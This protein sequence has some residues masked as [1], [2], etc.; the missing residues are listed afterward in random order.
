MKTL[1]YIALCCAILLT[2][3]SCAAPSS[4]ASPSDSDAVVVDTVKYQDVYNNYVLYQ[5]L[6]ATEKV[7]YGM[8][9][10]A[11]R[12]HLSTETTIE[13]AEGRS[14][15]GI[16][17]SLANARLS[18]EE[19]SRLFESFYLD[20]PEFFFIDRTYSLA[21][22]QINNQNVYDTLILQY[23]MN[24]EQRSAATQQLNTAVQR[25]LKDRP[26]TDDDFETE[27][28]LHDALLSSRVYDQAA[29]ESSAKHPNAYSAYGAL[30]QGK[31]VCE[32]YAKAMQILLNSVSIPTTVVRGFS[33]ENQT[34]HMWNLVNINGENYYLDPTWND[35][36]P[37]HHYSYFN[38][39][40][41]ALKRTHVIDATTPLTTDCTAERDNYFIR[42]GTYIADYDRDTIADTIARQIQ[43]GSTAVH[44]QFEDGKYENGL[45][46]LKNATLTK[47]MVDARLT[48]GAHM[49]D[50][51]LLV[52]A[53]QNT[54]SIHKI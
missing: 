4:P 40:S 43:Q 36:E 1:K 23:T 31:A 52:R 10:T 34:G 45:L 17:I 49:W 44:L 14:V 5:Q 51:E 29:T 8:I 39:T 35:S 9:Y 38:I 15:S 42:S 22:Q 6:S 11:V 27:L 46:L 48:D 20:N 7:Y 54:I 3:S 21:G 28:Y 53:D 16:R 50:Y 32:G 30:V 12:D 24:A 2:L 47:K 25:L 26:V 41:A 33:A 19:T 37:Q 18:A 13:N